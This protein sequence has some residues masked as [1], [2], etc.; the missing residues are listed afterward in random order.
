MADVENEYPAIAADAAT[1]P[2]SAR[3][4][5]LLA[6]AEKALNECLPSHSFSLTTPAD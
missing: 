3:L 5:A 4:L 6:K 1:N 2:E